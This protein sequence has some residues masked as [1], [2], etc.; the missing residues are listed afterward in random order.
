MS[1]APLHGLVLAGGASSRMHTDKAA[2]LYDGRT[3][4]QRAV[5]LLSR[6]VSPVFISVRPSQA[7]DP[8]RSALPMIVDTV[9][10]EGPIAGICS[11]MLAH[12]N[13]AWLVIACDLPFLSD[14]ALA[15]LI[16]ARRPE[17]LATAYRSAHDGLP[18]PLCA[19]W[20]PGAAAA[21]TVYRAGGGS[22]PRK[23]LIRNDTALIDPAEFRALDNINTPDEYAEAAGSIGGHVKPAL[24]RLSIQY[25][26]LMREQANCAQESIETLAA[27]PAEVFAE[28]AKKHRFTLTHDQMKVAVN[29]EFSSWTQCLKAGDCVV[30]IPPVAGG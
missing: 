18:E 17:A 11:A 8:L 14:V 9:P 19:I 1:A 21:L 20:E 15:R 25:F 2:L 22:C 27:T 6:H 29:G 4:L 13:A 7:T 10:G 3:Q 5:E 23:F 30:F 24:M 12:P 26:A 16:G 28:L